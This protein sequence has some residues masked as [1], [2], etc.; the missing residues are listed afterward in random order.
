MMSEKRSKNRD[1]VW[2]TSKTKHGIKLEGRWKANGRINKTDVCSI[3]FY[4][5]KWTGEFQKWLETF[6]QS[7]MG[8]ELLDR[9]KYEVGLQNGKIQEDDKKFL[10]YYPVLE[11]EV[12]KNCFLAKRYSKR[13]NQAGS[14]QK[15]FLRKLRGDIKIIKNAAKQINQ[16]ND[17]YPDRM[18]TLMEKWKSQQNTIK[19]LS[20]PPKIPKQLIAPK[21]SKEKLGELFNSFLDTYE[22]SADSLLETSNK[23]K[24]KTIIGPLV[25]TK[26]LPTDALRESAANGLLLNLIYLFAHYRHNETPRPKVVFQ[27]ALP[28]RVRKFPAGRKVNHK[29][30]L[31]FVTAALPNEPWSQKLLS[32][33]NRY[34]QGRE[35]VSSLLNEQDVKLSFWPDEIVPL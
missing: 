19:G 15:K 13:K 7:K 4:D 32:A 8:E 30:A 26:A 28:G 1:L 10:E 11:S 31:D 23:E 35:R 18:E 14:D 2:E 33:K 6:I 22:Y 9:L 27:M 20:N 3:D 5:Y 12:L 16:F 25:Y 24:S 29:L 34:K 21:Y 17:D